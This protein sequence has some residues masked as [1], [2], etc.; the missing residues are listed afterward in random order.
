MTH[1]AIELLNQSIKHFQNYYEK[2]MI[3]LD[4]RNPISDIKSDH[5][6]NYFPRF[7][8]LDDIKKHK[9]SENEETKK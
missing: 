8:K 5:K 2:L 7:D 6:K 1:R 4:S 9:K 3:E